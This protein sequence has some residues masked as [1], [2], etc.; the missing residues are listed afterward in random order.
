MQLPGEE[1]A[2]ALELTKHDGCIVYIRPQCGLYATPHGRLRRPSGCQRL[3]GADRRC[4]PNGARHS[5]SLRGADAG[6]HLFLQQV[7]ALG[8]EDSLKQLYPP[9]ALACTERATAVASQSCRETRQ[10]LLRKR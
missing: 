6:C 2:L 3:H 5:G 8:L 4:L 10:S 9:S 7:R 1:A